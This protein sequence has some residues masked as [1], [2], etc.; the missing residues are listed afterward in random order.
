MSNPTANME[1]ETQNAIFG[2][3]YMYSYYDIYYTRV[4][5]IVS[6]MKRRNISRAVNPSGDQ[7]QLW[8]S[9]LMEI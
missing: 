8:I 9:Y 4:K 2:K 1:T 6:Y 5:L 3:Y 7:K